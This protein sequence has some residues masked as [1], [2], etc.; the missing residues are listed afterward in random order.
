MHARP[1]P[2]RPV[3]ATIFR[4][5]RA[6]GV[7]TGA[8][9]AAWALAFAVLAARVAADGRPEFKT[10]LAWAVS[11]GALVLAL[12]FANW[13]YALWS[14]AYVVDNRSLTVRWGLRRV[15]IPIETIQRMVPGRTIDTPRVGGLNWWGCHVGAADVPRIGYTLFY[16]THSAPE[17]LLYLVT[18]EE[19]YALTISDQA[20]FAEEI[21]GRA[22]LAAVAH[23]PQRAS[24][25]GFAAFPFWRDRHAIVA[26]LLGAVACAALAG[27]VYAVYPGLAD[28]V[29]LNFPALGGVVRVGD[30]GEL[31]HIAYLGAGILAVNVVLGVLLHA[32]E[33]AAGLWLLASGGMLQAVLLAAALVAFERA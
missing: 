33:R 17:E 27:Y 3:A 21:Q 29:Q 19:S 6:L 16:S 9:L 25:T 15:L 31:L 24:A 28:V 23:L 20:A 14:L 18:T 7:I 22:A 11:A 4:P 2:R 26:T 8:G 12:V 32:R 30:K 5:P 1:R 13:A 10:F